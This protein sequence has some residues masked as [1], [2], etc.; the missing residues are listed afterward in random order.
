MPPLSA[1]PLWRPNSRA[2]AGRLT[3]LGFF[4]ALAVGDGAG[5]MTAPVQVIGSN[6]STGPEAHGGERAVVGREVDQADW[7]PCAGVE[8]LGQRLG[9][10]T[11]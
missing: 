4:V 10:G 7:S 8:R 1:P 2:S 9:S 11:A 5:V 3:A 6:A